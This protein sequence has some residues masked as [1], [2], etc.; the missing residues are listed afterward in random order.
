MNNDDQVIIVA[1]NIEQPLVEVVRCVD[2]SIEEEAIAI[3][4]TK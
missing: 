3:I 2:D 1:H 4:G